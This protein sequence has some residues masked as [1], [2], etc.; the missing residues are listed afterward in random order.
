MSEYYTP[1]EVAEML[2][3]SE[4]SIYRWADQDP[5]MPCVRFQPPGPPKIV[6]DKKGRTRRAPA[7]V[8]FPREPLERWLRARTQ[9][10]ARTRDPL[11]SSR[12]GAPQQREA[13]G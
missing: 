11:P 10:A 5:T 12:K 2:K 8:R 6:R 1:A 3:V 7:T 13:S 9:G 4:K